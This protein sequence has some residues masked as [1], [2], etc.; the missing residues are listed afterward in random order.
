MQF[1]RRDLGP[2]PDDAVIL[3]LVK[4]KLRVRDDELQRLNAQGGF[5]LRIPMADVESVELRAS[6][7]PLCLIMLGMAGAL[8]AVAYFVSDHMLLTSLLY[9]GAAILAG[10]SFFGVISRSFIIRTS[11][12]ET[13]V[14]CEDAPDEGACFVISLRQLLRN[15]KAPRRE[16]SD[17]AE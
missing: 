2:I 6:F 1:G 3:E 10:L 16:D 5:L 8:A 4:T 13:S 9:V 14:L 17:P 7:D 12:G 15:R 11:A